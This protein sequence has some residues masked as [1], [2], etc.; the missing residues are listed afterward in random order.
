MIGKFLFGYCCDWYL[1]GLSA[2][3]CGGENGDNWDLVSATLHDSRT[4]AEL[5]WPTQIEDTKKTRKER[6]RYLC[7]YDVWLAVDGR[8][9]LS[10]MVFSL[11]KFC[12]VFVSLCFWLRPSQIHWISE[13]C[14]EEKK[15]I[16]SSHN[17]SCEWTRFM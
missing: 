17:C 14:F 1:L 2:D 3:D 9:L 5:A 7:R 6:E 16:A 12:V 13:Q 8:I 15:I 11:L 10:W 4:F